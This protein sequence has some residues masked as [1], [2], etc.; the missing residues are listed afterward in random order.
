MNSDYINGLCLYVCCSVMVWGFCWVVSCFILSIYPHVSCVTLHFLSL[1]FS[2]PFPCSPAFHSLISSSSSFWF[3][4]CITL[5]NVFSLLPA[6][7]FVFVIPVFFSKPHLHPC[8]FF[9]I[10]SMCSLSHFSKGDNP[11]L[12]SCSSCNLEAIGGSEKEYK[13]QIAA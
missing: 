9:V 11:A 8:P 12:G 13:M 5:R 4:L 1:S 2:R 7:I 3:V 10:N 6:F